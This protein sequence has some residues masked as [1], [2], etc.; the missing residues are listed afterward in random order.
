MG[1][2]D[3][4]FSGNPGQQGLLAGSM[5][6]LNAGG[7]S[8]MPIS[9]GQALARG[10]GAG[11]VG[12]NQA[13]KNQQDAE[14]AAMQN[15]LRQAQ[16]QKMQAD[17][18]ARERRDRL[19]QDLAGGAAGPDKVENVGMALLYDGDPRGQAVLAQAAKMKES[20]NKQ[21]EFTG[22][23]A[24]DAPDRAGA[25]ERFMGPELAQVPGV[26]Q[27]AMALGNYV[28]QTPQGKGDAGYVRKELA[29]LD[30]MVEDYNSKML[31]QNEGA[32]RAFESE[33]GRKERAAE[34]LA[35]REQLARNAADAKK[36]AADAKIT[37]QTEKR[38]ASK[39][40]LATQAD[41]VLGTI[42]K[43]KN[44]TGWTTA[45]FGGMLKDIPYTLSLIH[46]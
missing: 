25:A 16:M 9:I 13:L 8:R 22:F 35:L 39:K 45:G 12:Y 24:T 46:I 6:M 34:S 37:E 38:E 15:E 18:A 33:Q 7:P 44:L 32:R 11:Q 41:V 31:T 26:H 42:T 29:A 28:Q 3:N 23:K 4:M 20:E 5:A 2:L 40:A 27:R 30:K 19:L 10:M 36:D 43:A 1:L 21:T 17:A 14:E